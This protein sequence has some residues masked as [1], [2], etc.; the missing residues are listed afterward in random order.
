MTQNECG[1]N[2]LKV[3]AIDTDKLK[4]YLEMEQLSISDMAHSIGVSHSNLSR[5]LSNQRPAGGRVWG[6][7]VGYFGRRIF[8]FISYDSNVPKGTKKEAG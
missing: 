7:L 5:V 4:S 2:K 1:V 6:G 3:A 8:E